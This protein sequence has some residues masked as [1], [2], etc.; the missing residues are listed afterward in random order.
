MEAARN[1]AIRHRAIGLG[2]LGYHDYLMSHSIP[3]ESAEAREANVEI[4]RFLRAE[5]EAASCEIAAKDGEPELLRGTGRRHATLIA[6]APTV[7]SGFILDQTSQGIE[8]RLSNY[9]VDDIAKG[10]YT[11]INPYLKRVLAQYG[12]DDDA[13][14]DSILSNEGSVQHL[15]FLS[16][17]ERDVF[18]T[19]PEIS[20]MEIVDQAA[21]RQP[22]IDQGQ[23][24]NLRV[25]NDTPLKE[26]NRLYMHGFKRGLKSFYYQR[27]FSPTQN[28]INEIRNESTSTGPKQ[29]SIDNPGCQSCEG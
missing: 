13:T 23:S 19:F 29:C 7:T 9:Y 20:P 28:L 12:R 1:F 6:I 15:G 27:G 16:Q 26:I 14:W 22:Y 8:P 3:F 24:L 2:I 4:F 21:D 18:K 5:A 10:K 17:H 25:K 11:I